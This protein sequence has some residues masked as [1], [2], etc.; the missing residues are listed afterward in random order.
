MKRLYVLFLMI[1][2]VSISQNIKKDSGK[3]R[4]LIVITSDKNNVDFMNQI[5]LL[6]NKSTEF[7]ERKLKIL[8]ALPNFFKSDSDESWNP[9]PDLYQK[10]NKEKAAFKVVLIG[11]DGGIKQSQTTVLSAEKLCAIIDGMPMRQRELKN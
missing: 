2:S 9:S 3:Y 6:K 1:T 4:V 10:F 7:E 11:L 8:Q 5:E